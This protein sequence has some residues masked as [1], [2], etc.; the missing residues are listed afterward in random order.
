MSIGPRVKAGYDSLMQTDAAHLA[1]WYSRPAGRRV[2]RAICRALQPLTVT[3]SSS[4]LLGLGYCAPFFNAS[5]AQRLE[6][7]IMAEPAHRG[8]LTALHHWPDGQPNLMT[9]VDA[10]ALP[11]ADAFF[12]QTTIVHALENCDEP[13]RFLREI[14]R[15][16]APGGTLIAIVPNRLGLWVHNKLTPFGYGRSFSR[17]EINNLLADALFTPNH[18]E[19]LLAM[20]P[21]FI[22]GWLN[23]ISLKVLGPM[24]GLHL[25]RATKSDGAQPLLT[26][27]SSVA[28]KLQT[29]KVQ[30]QA[31]AQA[32]GPLPL[33]ND[34]SALPDINKRL[35]DTQPTHPIP[36]S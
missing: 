2:S 26:K 15:V 29:A 25:I 12:D 11:F 30:T 36:S 9:P 4:R 21:S 33:Q 1:R 5:H 20:P 35:T 22:L 17:S 31:Q 34:A 8:T 16:T 24:G 7:C 13:Q 32:S 27:A 28:R 19:P 6:R 14:W 3:A 10:Y 23:P 18:Y